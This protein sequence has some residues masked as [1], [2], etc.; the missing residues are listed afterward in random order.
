MRN[1]HAGQPFDVTEVSDQQLTALLEDVSV[2]ALL[3]SCLHLVSPARRAELLAGELRPQG[4]FI[5]EV[6]GFMTPEQQQA[7][8]E[9][10]HSILCDYRDRGCPEPEPLSAADLHAIMGWLAVEPVPDEYLPMLLEELGFDGVDHRAPAPVPHAEHY[11]VVVV[12]AGM[13]GVLAAIRLEQAGFPYVVLEKNDGVGGTWWENT[14]PGA[15]VDVAS[16]F[17]SYSFEPGDHWSEFF[18]RQPELQAY[19][20]RVAAEHGVLDKIRFGAQ[21]EG[22]D[23]D[24]ESGTWQVRLASGEVVVGRA[25]V[26]AVGQLN[27]PQVPEFAGE[28][29][30]PAFHTA[31]WR[32]DVDLRGKRVVMIGAGATGFQIAPA[33]ADDVAS[34]T[35]I[36]RTAQWMFPN[37]G[38]HDVVGPGVAW[39]TRHVP[40]YGR[41]FRFLVMWPMCDTGLAA[42][43]VDPAWGPQERSVSEVSEMVRGMFTE[44]IA[45]QVGDDE[46]LLAQV[47]PD[48]PPT[49][50]RTLQDNGSWLRTLRRDHVR[51]VRAG[52]D[53][54]TPGGVVDTDGVEHP[55]DVVVFA[56]GF[57]YNDF[58]VPLAIRG[59]DAVDLHDSWGGHPGAHLGVTVAGFPNLFLLFGPG[60]NFAGGSSIVFGSECAVNFTMACLTRLAQ[61]EHRAVEVTAAAY[62]EYDRRL[63]AEM[64]TMVW[65]SPH[66]EHNYYR[67]EHGEVRGVNPFRFVDYWRWTQGPAD[68]DYD[69]R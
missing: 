36:Q 40:F 52:V 61:G 43:K 46:A 29:A 34:L 8:R 60:T 59:R 50:K 26:A 28:F 42:A 58:L 56:T 55:A 3:A 11:P 47:V 31:R 32:H 4:L 57:A 6:Q 14:Y 49:G 25:L 30:G 69:L 62:A 16:H 38:Y 33:I 37:A 67:N 20:A 13:S 68:E 66:I 2:P 35:V 1:S 18:S 45:S 39:A 15:R 21:V 9:L 22:A 63:Q 10:A 44:W 54:L 24:E 64:R 48:Y 51:L 5:N 7:G 17:Y 41:W 65:S 19:F 27:R 23:W 53:R 12:G